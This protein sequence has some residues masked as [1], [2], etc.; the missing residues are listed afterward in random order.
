MYYFELEIIL[1]SSYSKTGSKKIMIS[2][3]TFVI[4]CTNI[5]YYSSM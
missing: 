2:T 5:F 1:I 4:D 3:D